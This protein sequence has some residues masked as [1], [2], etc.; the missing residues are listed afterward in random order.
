MGWVTETLTVVSCVLSVL[1]SAAVAATSKFSLSS[2][3]RAG[4]TLLFWLSVADL[5]S[6]VVYLWPVHPNRTDKYSERMCEAQVS[7]RALLKR[8]N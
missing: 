2:S 1:G 6:A 7:L 8:V 3:R 5:C 4:K